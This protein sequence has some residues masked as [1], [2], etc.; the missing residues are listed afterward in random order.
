[1]AKISMGWT[2]RK[3][4]RLPILP[5]SSSATSPGG[6]H[7]PVPWRLPGLA[8]EQLHESLCSSHDVL[9]VQPNALFAIG[10]RLY[11]YL[12]FTRSW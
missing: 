7:R 12:S 1:M 11:A 8:T 5:E 10:H 9:Y 4:W 3:A 6:R 2:W